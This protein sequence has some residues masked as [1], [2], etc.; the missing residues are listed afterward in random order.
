M[1]KSKDALSKRLSTLL[2]ERK[3]V[4]DLLQAFTMYEFRN[5]PLGRGDLEN[6]IA[7]LVTA[8]LGLGSADLPGARQLAQ[9]AR[10][11]LVAFTDPHLLDKPSFI[12]NG[13]VLTAYGVSTRSWHPA[14]K[15][16]LIAMCGPL[17]ETLA[18]ML[19]GDS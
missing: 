3:Q 18:E 2:D 5:E 13:N 9:C 12:W 11:L 19:D 15:K 17:D 1:T 7:A 8:R 6:Q 4:R 14:L 16:R 10:E